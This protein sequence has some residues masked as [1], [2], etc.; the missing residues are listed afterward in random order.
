MHTGIDVFIDNSGLVVSGSTAFIVLTGNII[1]GIGNINTI[2]CI[3][4]ISHQCTEI[5]I[6]EFTAE[7]FVLLYIVY[8]ATERMFGVK[9][10]IFQIL[11][12]FRSIHKVKGYFR[13]RQTEIGINATTVEIPVPIIGIHL[14]LKRMLGRLFKNHIDNSP[15]R[16]ILGR[17][18]IHD[19][20]LLYPFHRH[21]AQKGF[22]LLFVHV[23]GFSV[24]DY[25]STSRPNQTQSVFIF[26]YSGQSG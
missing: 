18:T 19:L 4:I 22:E 3:D 5:V 12:I 11:Y 23:F 8:T 16:M 1:S 25:G 7:T 14:P 9:I 13:H 24:N 26:P 2:F 10:D 15:P 20:D 17:R 6:P 21:T